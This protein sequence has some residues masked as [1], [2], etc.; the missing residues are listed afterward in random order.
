MEKKENIGWKIITQIFLIF[1]KFFLMLL[2]VASRVLI[3]I[4]TTITNM[5]E[6]YLHIQHQKL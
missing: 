5:I 4:L 1:W 6:K 3:M 2:L